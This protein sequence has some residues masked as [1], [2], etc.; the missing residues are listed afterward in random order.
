VDKVIPWLLDVGKK[1]SGFSQPL[2]PSVKKLYIN[3]FTLSPL[4][5]ALAK[6]M[7]QKPQ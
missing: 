3:D 5:G 6:D 1:I 7:S 4:F 2:V